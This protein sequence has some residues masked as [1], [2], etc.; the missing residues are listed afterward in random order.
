MPNNGEKQVNHGISLGN[1]INIEGWCF[2]NA[3][4]WYNL[5]FAASGGWAIEVKVYNSTIV[6]VTGIDRSG[7][8]TAYITLYYTKSS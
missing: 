7:I 2:S 3:T 6:V 8:S 4:G 1:V 5:P